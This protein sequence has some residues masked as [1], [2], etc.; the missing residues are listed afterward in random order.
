MALR[1]PSGHL[2]GSGRVGGGAKEQFRGS[3]ARLGDLHVEPGEV[4]GKQ[5][6]SGDRSLWHGTPRLQDFECFAT[7]PLLRQTCRHAAVA[8]GQVARPSGICGV[9][10]GEADD[11]GRLGFLRLQRLGQ[12]APGR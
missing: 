1:W 12:I 8:H 5:R 10:F 2:S 9:G 6:L 7:L 4:L 11:D 3:F